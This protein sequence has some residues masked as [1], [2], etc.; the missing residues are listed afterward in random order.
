MCVGGV[1]EEVKNAFAFHEARDEVKGGLSV[2][3]AVFAGG[4]GSG[5][6]VLIIG[7][8]QLGKDLFDDAGDREI[9]KDTMV[10]VHAQ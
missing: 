1:S 2:L 9:L 10:Y 5:E 6:G 7:E 8:S 3:N 4:V